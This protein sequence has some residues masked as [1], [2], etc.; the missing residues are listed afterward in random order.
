MANATTSILTAEPT[1]AVARRSWP[2]WLALGLA[3]IA[4]A[5]VALLWDAAGARLLLGSIGLFL[6][7]RGALLVTSSGRVAAELAG[8]ARALGAVALAGGAGAIAAAVAVGDLAGWVLLA[9]LPSLLLGAGLAVVARGGEARRG[10]RALLLWAV[11]AT[12]VLAAVGLAV[13][14][15]R[16]VG[17][18][19]ALS[20]LGV[21]VLGVA[22]LV[23]AA[24]LRALGAL[25]DPEP[26]PA[27]P[28]GCGGCACGAGGCGA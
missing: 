18:A 1:P 6:A 17:V 3:A 27:R 9:G 20:A 11:A 25:P 19:T 14:W 5:V 7:V 21:A 13:S 22:A 4:V 28:V 10:G 23:G 16:A 8:R 15:D 2:R 24:N 12:A 26:E